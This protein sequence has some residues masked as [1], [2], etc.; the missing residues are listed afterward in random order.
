LFS[1]YKFSGL[2]GLLA[3][4]RLYVEDLLALNFMMN[5]ALLYLTARLT[6]RELRMGRLVAGGFLAA[7]YSLVIFWP[8]AWFVYSWAGK[9]GASALIIFFTFRPR[10]LSE[11]L[12]LCGAFF[13]ATFLTAGSVFALYY[14]GRMPAVVQGGVFYIRPPRPGF[15][16]GGALLTLLLIA[17]VWHFSER[18]QGRRGLRYRC[19]LYYRGREVEAGALL[20]TGNQL[21][22]P[23]SSRPLCVASFH[24]LEPLL[25]DVLRNAYRSGDNPVTA[26]SALEGEDGHRFGVTPFRSLENAGMLVTIRPEKVVLT[27]NGVCEEGRDWVFAISAQGLS[28]E[29]DAEILL[30]PAILET[31]GGVGC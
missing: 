11:A 24:C 13:M 1:A 16:F 17:G 8:G 18:Q 25:P 12:R 6:G 29:L 2:S 27:G 5:A 28:P 19:R 3:V 21:R 31:I 10:R 20:D 9:L 30:H 7:L 22:D 15:L 4:R 23:F 14:F 26:L